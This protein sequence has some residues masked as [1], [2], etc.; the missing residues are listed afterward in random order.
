MKVGIYGAGAMGTVLGA[1]I[2]KAGYEI[3]LINRNKEHVEALNKDG[4]KI[5]GKINFVQKVKALLPSELD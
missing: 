3:D 2:S 5:I 1:Y 4:A